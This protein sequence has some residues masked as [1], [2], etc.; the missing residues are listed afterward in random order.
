MAHCP[1]LY[2]VSSGELLLTVRGVNI[3]GDVITY[4]TEMRVSRD[5]GATWQ[6]PYKLDS[7]TGAYPSTVELRDGS[8]LV[9]YYEEGEVSSIRARRFRVPEGL[10]FL[11]L[12]G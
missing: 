10:K 8:V 2:R 4:S 12:E 5:E 6:G 7:T 1:H 9:V 3:E 11:P